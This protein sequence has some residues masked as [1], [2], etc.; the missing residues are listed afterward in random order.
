MVEKIIRREKHGRLDG[1]LVK[2]KGYDEKTWEPAKDLRQDILEMVEKF[3]KFRKITE[4]STR[5]RGRPPMRS[6]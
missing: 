5:K 4:S 3:E 2:W 1:Y 6:N